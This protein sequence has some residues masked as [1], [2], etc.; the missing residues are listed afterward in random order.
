MSKVWVATSV[1]AKQRIELCMI[2]RETVKIGI[3]W[4]F[5]LTVLHSPWWQN[6]FMGK[7]GYELFT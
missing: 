3:Q 6:V 5:F 7:P 1:V 4:L 2:A